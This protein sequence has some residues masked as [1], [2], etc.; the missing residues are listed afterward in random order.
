MFKNI[1]EV[2]LTV[3]WADHHPY[4]FTLIKV[5]P[6]TTLILALTKIAIE[7]LMRARR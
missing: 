7:L 4:L 3:G 1:D 5:A 6:T 2:L